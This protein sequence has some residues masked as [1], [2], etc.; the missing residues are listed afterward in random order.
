MKLNPNDAPKGYVAKREKEGE[1]CYGC[2]LSGL[3]LCVEKIESCQSRYRRDGCDVIFVRKPVRAPRKPRKFK[4]L[5]KCRL[6]G[7]KPVAEPYLFDK[8]AAEC[9]CGRRT[10]FCETAEEARV[11]WNRYLGYEGRK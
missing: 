6:C 5:F 10:S 3:P 4:G 7:K 11:E 8:H 2:H 9:E 1:S